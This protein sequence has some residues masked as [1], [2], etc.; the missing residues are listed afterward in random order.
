MREAGSLD[1]IQQ[2]QHLW[3]TENFEPVQILDAPVPLVVM[4]GVQ[5]RILQ[6]LMEQI[7]MDDTEQEI[8]VPK[9]SCPDRPPLRAVLSA[10]QIAEQLVEVPV[11][12]SVGLRSQCSCAAGGESAECRFSVKVRA[13]F[14]RADR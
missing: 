7:L 2:S 4:D 11:G 5:D 14:C 8:E 1:K 12:V 10:T 3:S 9:I 6:R 13:A